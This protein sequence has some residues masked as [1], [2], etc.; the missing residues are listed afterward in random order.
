M[1]TFFIFILGIFT[2][3]QVTK[4]LALKYVTAS[5]E[6]TPFFNI[7]LTLNR[8][9]SFGMFSANHLYGV[10]A[11]IGL[12]SCLSLFVLFLMITSK[13]KMDKIGFSMIFSGAVG[14]LFDRV[15]LGGVVDFLDFHIQGYHWP[16]FNVADSAICIGVCLLFLNQ[17]MI[18]KN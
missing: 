14:N 11:L 18:K 8:G 6:L 13:T 5:I 1:L 16:A 9:V 3:D 12:T 17:F 7:I 10:Y 4:I 2:L 15:R